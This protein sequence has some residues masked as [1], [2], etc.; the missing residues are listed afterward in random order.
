MGGRQRKLAGRLTARP[1]RRVDE[2][3][4]GTKIRYETDLSLPGKLG[5]LGRPVLAAKA[6]DMEKQ[7]AENLRNA[8]SAPKTEAAI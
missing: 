4:D 7:F 8:F 3:G 6:K 2:G 5:S 1:V